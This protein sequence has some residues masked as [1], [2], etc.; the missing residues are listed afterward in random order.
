MSVPYILSEQLFVIISVLLIVELISQLFKFE[1]IGKAF[2]NFYVILVYALVGLTLLSYDS[3]E[4]IYYFAVLVTFVNS[5]RYLLYKVPAIK[6]GPGLRFFL[7]LFIVGILIFAVIVINN[8]LVFDVKSVS[9]TQVERYGFLIAVVLVLLYEMMQKALEIGV[10][11]RDFLPRTFVSFFMVILSVFGSGFMIFQ[12]F[13]D[14]FNIG[15]N[16]YLALPVFIALQMLVMIVN[17]ISRNDMIE[18]YSFLYMI[19]TFTVL[20]FFVGLFV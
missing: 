10:D 6:D 4:L 1:L 5:M 14:S 9:V 18:S 2:V 11:I 15:I 17:G 7:D 12:L 16:L 3:K 19:P 8:M 13:T 20:A